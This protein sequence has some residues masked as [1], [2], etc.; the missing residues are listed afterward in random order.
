MI[1]F[2]LTCRIAVLAGYLYLVGP[3]LLNAED[4]LSTKWQDYSEDDGR[5]RVI[6]KYLGFEKQVSSELILKGHGVYDSISGSTPTGVPAEDGVN[7]PLSNLTDVREAGVVDLDWIRGIH[8]SSFQFSYSSEDDFLSR[9]YAFSQTTEINQRNTGI[10]YGIGYID[11]LVRPNFLDESQRKDSY[12]YFV[13]ISQVM[14][15]NTVVALN[16][17]Y[18]D[19]NGFLSDPYKIIQ[20]ETEILPGLS[21]PLTFPENRPYSRERRIWFFNAKRY[22]DGI[23]ASLDFDYRHF[24]DTWGVE[25][26]TFDLEWYQK[27]GDNLILRP[28]YRYYSQNAADFY[29]LGLTGTPID[30]RESTPGVAPHYSADYRLGKFDTHTYGLKIIYNFWEKF[31]VDVALEHYEMKGKDD[32]PQSAFADADVLTIGATVWF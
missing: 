19:Y 21:L 16:F 27:L 20:R 15:P 13:G 11:D 8:T 1:R 7:V 28:K 5:I 14:D 31:S 32:T 18:S 9:G 3:R 24:S 17:T 23:G 2:V 25:S 22:F 30:P 4:H 26:N 10:N 29:T 12:D 6:S